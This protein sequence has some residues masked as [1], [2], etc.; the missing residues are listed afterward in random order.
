MG[1]KCSQPELLTFYKRIMTMTTDPNTSP[2]IP[3]DPNQGGAAFD[4][5]GSGATAG[6]GELKGLSDDELGDGFAEDDM[7]AEDD[8]AEEVNKD[9]MDGDADLDPSDD[10][11]LEGEPLDDEVADD[12]DDDL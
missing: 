4:N 1:A 7:D 11:I 3:T 2:L 6:Y 9:D 12:L 5:T 8:L 10:E